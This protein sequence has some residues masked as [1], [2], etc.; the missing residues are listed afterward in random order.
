MTGLALLTGLV[1][2]SGITYV[3]TYRVLTLRYD[4]KG[5]A[6]ERL[7]AIKLRKLEETAAEQ[8]HEA[9]VEA[10]EWVG[11]LLDTVADQRHTIET[12]TVQPAVQVEKVHR[13]QLDY[14]T[15]R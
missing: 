1:A 6:H 13:Y 7:K 12:L 14:G 10:K 2:G 11:D 8:V 4:L 9:R 3:I 5:Y 15:H